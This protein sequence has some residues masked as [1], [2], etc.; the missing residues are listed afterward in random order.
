MLDTERLTISST[1]GATIHYTTD[2]S[3]P[4]RAEPGVPLSTG[5]WQFWIGGREQ[6]GSWQL[7]RGYKDSEMVSATFTVEYDVDEDN[8][9]LIEIRNLEMFNNI[10]YNLA[11]TSYDDELDDD[12]S[13]D[14]ENL[15]DSTGAPPELPAACEGRGEQYSSLRI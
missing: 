7:K 2:G 10:R 9:G 6:S 11:G 12:P 13:D 8:D 4:G 3:A 5:L 15:G 14:P 1:N